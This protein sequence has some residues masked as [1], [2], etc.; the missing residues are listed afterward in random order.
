MK[1][2]KQMQQF[3][4]KAFA[5]MAVTCL[6]ALLAAPLHAGLIM[7]INPSNTNAA[8]GSTG[9]FFDV[10][11]TNT[12]SATPG[13][14]GFSFSLTAGNANIVFPGATT[15][16]IIGGTLRRPTSVNKSAN[17]SS[18]KTKTLP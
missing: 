4:S 9:D 5:V 16:A 10:I 7:S 2:T 3:R 11:L 15:A 8:A 17:I 12:T 13:V 1:I 6:W 14:A 18:G